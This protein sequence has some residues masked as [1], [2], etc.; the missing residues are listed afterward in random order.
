MMDRLKHQEDL[1]YC[2]R[3]LDLLEKFEINAKKRA[4]LRK[5]AKK[6]LEHEVSFL[7]AISASILSIFLPLFFI[8]LSD[9]DSL[10]NLSRQS[11]AADFGILFFSIIL[12]WINLYLLFHLIYRKGIFRWSKKRVRKRVYREMSKEKKQIGREHALLIKNKD[13]LNARIPDRFLNVPAISYLI[14]KLEKNSSATLKQELKE[15]EAKIQD[16]TF[17]RTIVMSGKTVI[18]REREN[19]Y[20]DFIAEIFK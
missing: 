3:V 14:K 11:F 10:L 17:K 16:E 13:L 1:N 18:Q 19:H 15:L 2:Y 12:L 5:K 20:L 4:L 9:K 8:P 6:V 7:T